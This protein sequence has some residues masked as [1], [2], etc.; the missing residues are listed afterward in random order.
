M[1]RY[2]YCT[3]VHVLCNVVTQGPDVPYVT[4]TITPVHVL[5]NVVA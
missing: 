5:C 2:N 3:P 4:I 1:Y